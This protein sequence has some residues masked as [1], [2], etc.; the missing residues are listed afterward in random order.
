MKAKLIPE[1][2]SS[3]WIRNDLAPSCL[4]SLVKDKPIGSFKQRPHHK[5]GYWFANYK[6]KLYPVHRVLWFLDGNG[7][8][9]EGYEVDHIDRNGANNRR[10]NLRLLTSTEQK[11]N[12]LSRKSGT[13]QYKGVSW[14]N[15]K[16]K[17]KSQIQI[18]GNKVFIGYFNTELEA[19]VAYDNYAK[20]YAPDCA[21]LNFS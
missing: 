6:G 15:S 17:W 1:S 13:S 20:A 2:I 14:L 9:P 21:V 12:C 19:A 16:R 7:Q 5:T 8:I 3:I 11:F 4:Y 10:T 18:N